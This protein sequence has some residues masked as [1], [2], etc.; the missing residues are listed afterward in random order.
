MVISMF[1]RQTLFVR[2]GAYGQATVLLLTT[3]MAVL[4]VVYAAVY[5][6]HLGAEKV[7]SAN[8]IDSIALSAATWE[9]RGLNVIAGLNDG[10]Q[11]CFRLI[12]WTCVLWAAMA[13]AACTGLGLPAFLEYSKRAARIIRSTWRTA[14]QFAKWAEKVKAAIPFIILAETAN[15]S[16]ELKV[17]GALY[18]LDPR[19]PHDDERTLELHLTLSPPLTLADA[20]SPIQRVKKKISKWK[21]AKKIVRRIVGIIDYALRPLLGSNPAPVVMLIPEDHLPERQQVRFSGF[22]AVSP[23]R[24]PFFSAASKNRFYFDTCAEPYGGGATD[25]TWKSRFTEWRREHGISPQ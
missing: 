17:T 19:G 25:M 5:V 18:P 14:Q 15:L 23:I 10:I 4:S 8:A 21:W 12:R 1:T 3:L 16:R 11:Q 22:K 2:Q 20:L 13:I 24:I 6:A 9:A 7:A